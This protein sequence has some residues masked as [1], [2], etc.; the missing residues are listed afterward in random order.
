MTHNSTAVEL[1]LVTEPTELSKFTDHTS[2]C[3]RPDGAYTSGCTRPLRKKSP[4]ACTLCLATFL[5][6]QTVIRICTKCTAADETYVGRIGVIAGWGRTGNGT[7]VP[8]VILSATVPIL[9]NAA[10][11]QMWE[12]NL[13]L[14]NSYQQHILDSQ[15]CTGVGNAA[16]CEVRRCPSSVAMLVLCPV[17]VAQ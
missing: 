8:E 11:N 10:C 14:W 16:T 3:L 5:H 6:S 7:V 9:D 15:E 1:Q 4:L 17:L 12:P 2:L 13:Q